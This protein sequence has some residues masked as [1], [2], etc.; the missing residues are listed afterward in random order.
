MKYDKVLA[1]IQSGEMSRADLLKLKHN[2]EDKLKSGDNDA[3]DILNAINIAEPVDDYILFMGFCPDANIDNRLDVEWK[4]KGVC[5]F[6]YYESEV[7]VNR[8]NEIYTGDLVVLKKREKF[9]KTM[10][11]Y[12]H[13]RVKSIAHDE[14]N[15]RY[16]IMDWSKQEDIIEVPLMACNSTVDVKSIDSV[17][18][19]MPEEFF[20]WLGV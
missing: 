9:G 6:D 14:D 8:F 18:D 2:A 13:G 4:E 7:Q 20:E 19:V 10:K 12:G 15:N 17:N 3:K 11:L 5:I 16:L 1:R